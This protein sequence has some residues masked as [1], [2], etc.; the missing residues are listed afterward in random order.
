MAITSK[1]AEE[2]EARLTEL[3]ISPAD[4]QDWVMRR[5]YQADEDD[6][7]ITRVRMLRGS[8][9]VSYVYASIHRFSVVSWRLGAISL[10]SVCCGGDGLGCRA[11]E[12]VMGRG[13]GLEHRLKACSSA[14]LDG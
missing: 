1:K 3:G 6:R 12:G 10:V 7:R 9:G 14:P 11:G 8:H 2:I 4:L 13:G 5:I